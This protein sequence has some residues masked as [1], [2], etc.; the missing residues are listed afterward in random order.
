MPSA[1]RGADLP[2]AFLVG[3]VKNAFASGGHPVG[4]LKR[5]G[6]FSDAGRSTDQDKRAGDNTAPKD[7]VEFS[8]ARGSACII[9]RFNAWVG[10]RSRARS[11]ACE[12]SARCGRCPDAFFDERVP[13]AAAGALAKPFA[14][15]LT[16]VLTNE[17]R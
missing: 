5:D 17:D 13:F 7:T 10:N 1:R 2:L 12:T 15:G 6:R 8:N 9:L 3:N 4:D 11:T 14:S 16:A